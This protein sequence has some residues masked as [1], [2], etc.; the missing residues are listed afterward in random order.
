MST[1]TRNLHTIALLSS[2]AACSLNPSYL[3]TNINSSFNDDQD[4]SLKNQAQYVS[5]EIPARMQTDKYYPISITFINTGETIWQSEDG[6]MLKSF[7]SP[8]DLWSI[9]SIPLD[10]KVYPQ[11]IYTFTFQVT[12]PLDMDFA[13]LSWRMYQDQAGMFGDQTP[14]NSITID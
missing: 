8:T 7:V 13:P 2:L 10:K 4:R 5:Q 11:D 3:S 9:Q 1:S 6:Y 14:V 12:P